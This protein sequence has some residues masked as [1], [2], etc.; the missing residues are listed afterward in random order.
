MPTL[1]LEF[2]KWRWKVRLLITLIPKFFSSL[3]EYPQVRNYITGLPLGYNLLLI[4]HQYPALTSE[5]YKS[6]SA[7]ETNTFLKIL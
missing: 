6:H 2:C 3:C 7:S 4:H 1:I 5:Q